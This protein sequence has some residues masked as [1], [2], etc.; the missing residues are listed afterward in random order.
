[1]KSQL[2]SIIILLLVTVGGIPSIEAGFVKN[3]VKVTETD[4]VNLFTISLN[5]CPGKKA[6][7]AKID[8]WVKKNK[9]AVEDKW[10]N[11]TFKLCCP[12]D[13]ICKKVKIELDIKVFE[14]CPKKRDPKKHRF[15]IKG[16]KQKGRVLANTTYFHLNSTPS[17]VAHEVGHTWGLNEEYKDGRSRNNLMG[18][19]KNQKKVEKYHLA[20]LA[21][22]FCGN[23][24]D[25]TLLRRR[26][27]YSGVRVF[28]MKEAKKKA[29]G[30]GTTAEEIDR[31]DQFV[32][33]NG[34]KVQPPPP[35]DN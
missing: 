14:K 32:K 1:M 21:Y 13:E 17:V 10:N 16:T 33:D 15:K 3:H 23:P 9:E 18:N 6:D 22:L 26:R 19:G 27:A 28:G 4:K 12:G 2:L 8:A 29:K 35:G 7:K 20:L 5:L 31:L 24:D 30:I 25:A 11:H 34:T